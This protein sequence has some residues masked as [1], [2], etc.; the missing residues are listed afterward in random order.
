MVVKRHEQDNAILTKNIGSQRFG[1]ILIHKGLITP[2]F[3]F[4]ES[5][6]TLSSS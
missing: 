2:S 3:N 6:Y 4:S 5:L 1:K